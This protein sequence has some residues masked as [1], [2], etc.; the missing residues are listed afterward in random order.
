MTFVMVAV[1]Y[2]MCLY[3]MKN[4][5]SV[6]VDAGRAVAVVSPSSTAAKRLRAVFKWNCSSWLED[7]PEWCKVKA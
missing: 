5:M 2:G 6:F 4:G 7:F 1:I 3:F